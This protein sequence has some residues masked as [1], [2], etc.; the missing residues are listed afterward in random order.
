MNQVNSI[1]KR[2][3]HEVN[4][5][6][7]DEEES[8]YNEHFKNSNVGSGE[9][10]VPS[11]RVRPVQPMYSSQHSGEN[12][13]RTSGVG[14]NEGNGKQAPFM[15]REVV[16][17][18]DLS[19]NW[20]SGR[21]RE[22]ADGEGEA[23]RQN[24]AAGPRQ[25]LSLERLDRIQLEMNPPVDKWNLMYLTLILHGVGTLMPWN[26]FINAKTVSYVSRFYC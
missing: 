19:S 9:Y 18:E 2:S 14:G 3:A 6:T 13:S 17:P 25:S 22:A 4:V 1:L 20:E 5:D 8:A 12:Y 26:I 24:D 11:V 23:P 21:I 16:I 10:R 7:N 15:E